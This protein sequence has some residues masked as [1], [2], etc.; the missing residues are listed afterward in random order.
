MKSYAFAVLF[1]LPLVATSQ[2][3]FDTLQLLSTEIVYFDF[4]KYDISADADSVIR[5]IVFYS[6]D[7][8][9]ALFYIHAHTDAIGSDQNNMVLSD[10]RARAV[11]KELIGR[12]VTVGAV[13]L[14]PYGEK[15]PV[16]SN[17]DDEGRQLNR[18]AIIE[19]YQPVSMFTISGQVKDLRT[20]EGL[21]AS[22]VVHS[23]LFRDSMTTT[24]DGQFSYDVPNGSV[25]GIDAYAEGYFFETQMI[26]AEAGTTPLIEI[27]LPPATEGESIDIKNLYFRG[28]QA[29]LLP[30]SRPEL[31]KVLKFMQF[32]PDLKIEIAGHVNR[33][34][35]GPVAEDSWSFKLSV[36]R[37]LLVYNHLLENGIEEARIEYKGYGNSQMRYPK[38]RSAKH[39]ELNRRV[40]IRAKGKNVGKI[41][42]DGYR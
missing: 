33:P 23:K 22:I 19:I 14:R 29:V 42:E 15:S 32:N 24:P 34:N 39:Q 7:F 35:Q 41:G 9:D 37:A 31:D 5:E 16:A 8:P 36:R 17:D 30:R 40:E 38:A 20:G 4:G 3:T 26:K 28:N 21:E 6:Q 11:R 10:N 13:R 2:D 27:E 18:R 12:G 25:V 1:L